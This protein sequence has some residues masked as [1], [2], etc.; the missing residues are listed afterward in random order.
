MKSSTSYYTSSTLQES[1]RTISI[2]DRT[3]EKILS[4]LKK[5]NEQLQKEVLTTFQNESQNKLKKN[6]KELLQRQQQ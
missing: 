1:H 2:I 6:N 4:M 5:N 3:H